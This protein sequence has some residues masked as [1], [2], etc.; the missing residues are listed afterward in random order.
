MTQKRTLYK[1]PEGYNVN[2]AAY[3]K[4]LK[5]LQVPYQLQTVNSDWGETNVIVAGPENA[6]SVVLLH[7]WSVNAISWVP[8]INDFA[9]TYRVYVPDAIGQPG[10]SAPV[11]TT[12]HRN[13][14]PRWL[15]QVFDGLHIK[16]A[17][18]IGIS[19]GG[20]LAA[21]FAA[22]YSSRVNKVVLMVPAGF[23]FASPEFVARGLI[24]A[25]TASP[26]SAASLVRWLSAPG[27]QIPP[28]VIEQFYA[29]LKYWRNLPV[30]S[31]PNNIAPAEL[32]R[33]TAPVLLIEGLYDNVFDPPT[34]VK[35]ARQILPNLVAV[36][37]VTQAGHLVSYEQPEIVN[38]MVLKFLANS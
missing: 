4:A 3:D 36:E 15:A 31:A 10:R 25:A 19:F 29:M 34:V 13:D 22:L 28:E 21:R 33:I 5:K 11:F 20:W 24:S 14:Y 37:T 7:G 17:S 27:Y 9:K 23:T 30:S 6:P 35:R 1:S 16:Q 38:S 26:K 12:P 2:I 18:V 8:Q 32:R